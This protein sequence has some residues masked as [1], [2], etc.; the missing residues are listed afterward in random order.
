MIYSTLKV[1][2]R[3]WERLTHY[4]A[5]MRTKSFDEAI[6]ILLDNKC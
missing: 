2:P 4:K 1:K 3:T 5:T 6:N